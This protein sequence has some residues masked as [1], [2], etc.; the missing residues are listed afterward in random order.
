M[1]K[2]DH[3]LEVIENNAGVITT[4]EVL[5]HGF[6]KDTLK[7][8][9][10]DGKLEKV[11]TGLYAF[12]HE[13]IDEY[14]YFT[15]R[16]K[17]GVFSHETA[18]YLQGLTTKIPCNY[19]MTIMFGDNVSRVTRLKDNIN[20]KY[21][22]KELFEIGKVEQLSPFGRMLLTYDK[23]RTVL[24]IIR[25]KDRIEGQIFRETI[26]TYFLNTDMNILKLSQYAVSMNMEDE[27]TQYTEIMI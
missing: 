2:K 20:F 25:D 19:V 13:N 26:R 18:A 10:V 16:I 22:D 8:L 12:P 6:H 27:L 5:E 7:A 15:H 11:A 1:K 3:L 17:K 14:L 21:V 9:V 23:E 4:K 24:D